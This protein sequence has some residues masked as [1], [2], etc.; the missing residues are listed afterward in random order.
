MASRGV[1]QPEDTGEHLGL[2][3]NP[4]VAKVGGASKRPSHRPCPTPHRSLKT[5]CS[6]RTH[7]LGN[8][9]FLTL[10]VQ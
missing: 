7:A 4:Y 10:Q 2:F 9:K 3:T 5:K 8:G 6:L 1:P